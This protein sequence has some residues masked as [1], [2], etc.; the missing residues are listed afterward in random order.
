MSEDSTIH[1]LAQNDTPA[2]VN[3]PPTINGVIV[4][5]VGRF[6]GGAVIGVLCLYGLTNVYADLKASNAA[7]L[8]A[9]E[10]N[11]QVN[12]ETKA[13]LD[14]LKGEIHDAHLRAVDRRE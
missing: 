3:V 1:Q 6:G 4:W 13:A 9:F 8:K 11:V 7:L 12:T 5:A 10:R 14:A 2:S